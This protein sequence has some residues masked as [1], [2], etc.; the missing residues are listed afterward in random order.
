MK[1]EDAASIPITLTTAIV[2]LYADRQSKDAP[3]FIPPWE[4]GGRDK[5]KGQPILITGG[6][7]SVGQYGGSAF[8]TL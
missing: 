8:P 1:F 6:S 2:G 5:Y 7:T 3:H 4:E